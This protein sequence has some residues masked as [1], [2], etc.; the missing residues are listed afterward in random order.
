MEDI[1]YRWLGIYKKLPLGLRNWVGKLYE[2]IPSNIRYGRFYGIYQS[3][4]KTYAG[5]KDNHQI[6]KKQFEYLASTVNAARKSVSAYSKYNE[7]MNTHDFEELPVIS[8]DTLT[9][10]KNDYINYRLAAKGIKANTGGSS[11]TPMEFLIQS[12]V[13][14]VKEKAHFD[15]Y[16]GQFGY[17][18]GE[19]I[20]MVRGAPLAEGALFERQSI[21]N[22]LSVSCYAV[23]EENVKAVIKE[24]LA[25]KPKYIHAYP[26]SLRI[27]VNYVGNSKKLDSIDIQAIFLGS[28]YL[29]AED[30]IYFEEFFGARVVNWYGHSE[31]LIHG[32]NC[33]FSNEYHFYPSYGYIELLDDRN[34][35]INKPNI[36]GRI[37]ATGFDNEVMP[38]IRYDTGDLG[39]LSEIEECECGFIGTSLKS[40]EGRGKDI[41]LLSDGSKVSLTAFIFGQHFEEFSKITELQI[42]QDRIGE[43]LVRLVQSESFSSLDE[44]TLEDK[45]QNSVSGKIAIE[46]EYVQQIEKTH[47]GKHRFLV[48]NIK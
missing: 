47:R 28:E 35:V 18:P 38:L 45:M 22:K 12:G 10:N 25:F 46:F 9:H 44:Q 40:I 48:Q 3:R 33:R 2:A 4:L 23:N 15:W 21:G 17:I 8:K 31:C 39:M 16:W 20:L 26:S 32:G 27:L 6:R 41:I 37:V 29:F 11:G 36:V 13:T 19:P 42:Q 14:R 1:L 7:L 24:I 30:R 43:I 5:F 34:Q